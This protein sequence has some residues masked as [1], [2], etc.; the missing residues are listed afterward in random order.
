LLCSI[1]GCQ[2]KTGDPVMRQAD[3]VASIQRL[4]AP[5]LH[6]LFRVS[7]RIYSGSSPEGAVGFDSLAQLGIKTIVSVDGAKPDVESAARHGMEYVHLPFGYDGI[8]RDRVL[9]L[10]KLVAVRPGPLY[11][12]CHHGLHRGPVAVAVMQLCNQPAWDADAAEMWLQ[13]A[14][15]SPQYPGLIHLPRTLKCPSADELSSAPNEF[16]ATVAQNDLVGAMVEVDARWDRLKLV[17]AAQWTKPAGHPDIDPPHE[18]V[19]LI[20]HYREAAR[21]DAV[22]KRG[23]A[24]VQL[25]HDAESA[26]RDLETQLR[27]QP[28]NAERTAAAFARAAAQCAACHN[29]FRD[30]P[31]SA[32]KTP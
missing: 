1:V 3:I 31:V 22:T 23:P 17:K 19:Q 9:A 2:S 4:E 26:T 14:G 20:E 28:I 32:E 5:G 16:P 10:A 25:F 7:D 18:V 12:H 30:V 21:L 27:A 13:Q 11:V 15:T 29:R 24:L 6:N 8:P